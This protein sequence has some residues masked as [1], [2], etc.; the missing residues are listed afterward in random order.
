MTDDFLLERGYKKYGRSIYDN[1]YVVTRFQK[2]FDD[3]FGKK[4]F[5][6]IIKISNNFVP[7]HLRRKE[8][9]EPYT[10]SYEVQVTQSASENALNLEFYPDWKLEDVEEFMESMFEKMKLNYYESWEAE[11]RI[12]HKEEN[13]TL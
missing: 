10:Y 11:R 2:R 8:G 12:R 5:I 4:Y 7:E 3:D 6:N 1:D 13:S 9:W